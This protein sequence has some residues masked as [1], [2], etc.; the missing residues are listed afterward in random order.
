LFVDDSDTGAEQHVY[1]SNG[2]L[3]N[4]IGAYSYD[5]AGGT[6]NVTY[7]A[8]AE[9]DGNM[10]VAANA[11]KHY[12]YAATVTIKPHDAR[13]HRIAALTG[14]LIMGNPGATQ[15]SDGERVTVVIEQDGTGSRTITWYANW[16]VG[17]ADPTS[18]TASAVT[19]LTFIGDGSVLRLINYYVS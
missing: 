19:T 16:D 13:V 14:N 5:T 10:V 18:T 9:N 3:N 11:V 4:V 1:F 6:Q 7:A 2:V 17:A 15:F 8:G 12:A